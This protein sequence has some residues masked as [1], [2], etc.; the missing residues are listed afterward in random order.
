MSRFEYIIIPMWWFPQDIIDQYNVFDLVGK[1]GFFYVNICNGKYGL[2]QLACI[3]FYGLVK[4]LKNHGYYPIP[5]NPG[6]W[7]H[8][9]LP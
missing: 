5:Y 7:C 3:D 1:D 9:T 2:K 4:L 6:I 8:E